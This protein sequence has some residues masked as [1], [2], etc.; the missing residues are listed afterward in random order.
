MHP[1]KVSGSIAKLTS[2]FHSAGLDDRADVFV[3]ALS[4]APDPAATSLLNN[5][6]AIWIKERFELLKFVDE[7]SPDPG[8]LRA[9]G[10]HVGVS[11]GRPVEQRRML[12]NYLMSN[13]ALPPIKDEAYMAQWGAPNSSV[14]RSKLI[15][16]LRNLADEKIYFD[17]FRLAVS[18]WLQDAEYVHTKWSA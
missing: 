9:L 6:Q 11:Q 13:E 17:Q 2:G 12:L 15:R 1:I 14:R 8:L 4:R 16:V 7:R 5:I 18:E 10:Y 3:R